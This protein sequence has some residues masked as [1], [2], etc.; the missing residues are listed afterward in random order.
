[1]KGKAF[2]IAQPASHYGKFAKHNSVQNSA[3]MVG[4]V[5]VNRG[6]YVPIGVVRISDTKISAGRLLHFQ[7][8]R[9]KR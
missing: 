2:L 5:R 3:G 9:I 6:E 1:M 7:V 4:G 8:K